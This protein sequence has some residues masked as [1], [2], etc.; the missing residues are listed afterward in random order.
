MKRALKAYMSVGIDAEISIDPDGTIRIA[1]LSQRDI[2]LRKTNKNN[3]DKD[4]DI[5]II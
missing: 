1:P 2:R 3:F 4:N 5:S